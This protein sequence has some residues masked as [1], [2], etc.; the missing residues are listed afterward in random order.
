MLD[1]Y[2]KNR[3][4]ESYVALTNIAI[5]ATSAARF[6]SRGLSRHL[7]A[8]SQIGIDKEPGRFKCSGGAA[9]DSTGPESRQAA[10]PP[11]HAVCPPA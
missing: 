4:S 3:N 6:G 10:G 7:S 1:S 8:G 5:L 2:R 9:V 11:L